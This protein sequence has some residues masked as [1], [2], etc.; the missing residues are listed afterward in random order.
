MHPSCPLAT[1]ARTSVVTGTLFAAGQDLA[2]APYRLTPPLRWAP[3][4]LVWISLLLD[5]LLGGLG[6]KVLGIDACWLRRLGAARQWWL[7]AGP[8]RQRLR[9]G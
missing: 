1:L 7:G 5:G 6:Y 2:R 8:D 9:Y 3:H 4:M